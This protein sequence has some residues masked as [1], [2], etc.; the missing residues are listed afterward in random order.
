MVGFQIPTVRAPREEAVVAEEL[1]LRCLGRVPTPSEA[2]RI[3]AK[4]ASSA[5]KKKS[6]ED[7]FWA[8]LNTNEFLFN[9]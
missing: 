6:L 3:S 7:L 8:L 5:D 4:L 2:E 1:Y 9:H